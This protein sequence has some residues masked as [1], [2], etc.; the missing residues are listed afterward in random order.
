MI[1]LQ[2]ER[3]CPTYYSGK[4][5]KSFVYKQTTKIAVPKLLAWQLVT[6]LVQLRCSW[7]CSPAC[8]V[9]TNPLGCAASRQGWPG[10]GEPGRRAAG[11]SAKLCHRFLLVLVLLLLPA[12][13]PHPFCRDSDAHKEG[14]RMFWGCSLG[15]R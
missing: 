6:T 8:L 1:L 4:H 12:S 7:V 3:V 9:L 10:P 14:A 11:S 2:N 5:F 13:V 15:N